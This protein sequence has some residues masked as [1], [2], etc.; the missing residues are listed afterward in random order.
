M[1]RVRENRERFNKDGKLGRT[2]KDLNKLG[3]A[4]ENRERFNKVGKS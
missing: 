1:G 3:R 4:R 2:G